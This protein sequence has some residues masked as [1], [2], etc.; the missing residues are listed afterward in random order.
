MQHYYTQNPE[1]KEQDISFSVEV[2]GKEFQFITNS[3]VFSKHGLDFGSRLLIET[4]IRNHEKKTA[5][6]LDFGCGYGP[7]GIIIRSFFPDLHIT[8]ADINRR[9][10]EAAAKNM[11]Q[12]KVPAADCLMVET[13]GFSNIFDQYDCI[14]TNPP[15]RAG[16]QTVF[17]IYEEAYRHL[18]PKGKLYVVIQKKQG[19]PSTMEKLNLLFGNCEILER[20]SGYHILCSVKE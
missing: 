14:L 11:I 16:K 15:I 2:F 8:L 5:R 13:D 20:K 7:V 19:A 18:N 1:C 9:A 12:N 4:F 17:M 3:G 6:I 10:L